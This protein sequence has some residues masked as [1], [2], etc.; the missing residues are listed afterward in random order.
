MKLTLLHNRRYGQD[1]TKETRADAHASVDKEKRYR[2]ILDCLKERP[3]LT[4]KEIAVMLNMN[5]MIP[6]S[7]RNF[8]AP[9]LTEMTQKGLVE[10]VGKRICAY[11]GRMVTVYRIREV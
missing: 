5:G 10:P 9:R 8:T 3:E 4:A 2:Q 7:E 11:T 6:T 1:P